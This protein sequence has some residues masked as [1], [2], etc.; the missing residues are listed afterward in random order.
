[1]LCPE[2]PPLGTILGGLFGRNNTSLFSVQYI[3]VLPCLALNC[4][5]RS[6]QLLCFTSAA[7]VVASNE[8]DFQ[9]PIL[10]ADQ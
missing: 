6:I 2:M 5:H 1:M 8:W 10:P 4:A 9:V 7:P 3:V